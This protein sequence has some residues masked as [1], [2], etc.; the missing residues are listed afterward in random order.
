M[1]PMSRRH[2]PLANIV[3]KLTELQSY[4]GHA[5]PETPRL[6]IAVTEGRKWFHVGEIARASRKTVRAIH[7]YE[8][9]GLLRPSARS[10]GR[11]RLYDEAALT[12]VRWIGKLHEL[13]LSLHQIQEIVSA[14]EACPSAPEA[15]T[16]MRDVYAQKLD[17]TRE[18]IERLHTLEQEL[19]SSLKYLD[20]CETCDPNELIV[21]CTHCNLHSKTEPEPE[22]IAGI[23]TGLAACH[24]SCDAS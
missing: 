24:A 12:R 20:T 9:L 4:D 21:A 17:E 18:Q 13:G 16:K 23:H 3:P 1:S 15:M 7:H 5:E 19:V 2:L 6:H 14:W 8:D 11:Y 22:L 10:K